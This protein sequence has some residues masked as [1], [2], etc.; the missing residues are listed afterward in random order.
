MLNDEILH[1]ALSIHQ[2]S[3]SLA[4]VEELDDFCGPG[5]AHELFAPV[6]IFDGRRK[7]R[8]D[9]EIFS[10][11]LFWAADHENEMDGDAIEGLPLDPLFSLDADGDEEIG[12]AVDFG[13]GYRDAHAN[14]SRNDFFSF[15]DGAME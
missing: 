13:V 7:A 5:G 2:S 15:K 8:K 14:T 10:L 9:V 4:V 11:A 12:I 1:L 6:G 3:F